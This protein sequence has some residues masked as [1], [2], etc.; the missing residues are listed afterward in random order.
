VRK[1]ADAPRKPAGSSSVRSG[2]KKALDSQ[3]ATAEI[4]RSIAASQ[5]DLRGVLQAIAETAHRLFG[6][7]H[8]SIA[9]LEGEY[10]RHAAS[11]GEASTL[12]GDRATRIRV[13]RSSLFGRAVFDKRVV[14]VPDLERAA[15]EFPA[16]PSVTYG[17]IHTVAAA[18]LMRNGT[19][20]GAMMVARAEQRPFRPKELKLLESF[21]D[22]AVIAI[23]NAR[24]LEELNTRNSDLA[25]SLEQQTATA[26]ILRAIASSPGDANLVL[27][28]IAET[29]RRLFGALSTAITR[30][31]G[32]VFRQ[33]ASAGPF[34]DEL[35]ANL[36]NRPV[37]RGSVPGRA[38][39]DKRTVYIDDIQAR[40]S[41]FP[42][43]V[44]GEI[45]R[46]TTRTIVATPLLRKGEAIGH[47][48]VAH[49][50]VRPY[51]EKQIE[52]LESFA[53]QAVIAIE[54]A[55]L[56]DQLN[57]RNSDLA[58]SLEQRTATAEV[59][60]AIA[61][62]PG[63]ADLV[64]DTI[65]RTATRL[66]GASGSTITRID[67]GVFR[68]VAA[69]GEP[70]ELMQAGLSGLRVDR[71]TPP[72]R[73]VLERR[74]IHVEDIRKERGEFPSAPSVQHLTAVRTLLVT[75]LISEGEAIGTISVRREEVRPFSAKEI[76]LLESFADQAVIAIENA[77][78]LSELRESLDR[79]TATSE[80][81]R[82]IAATP[83]ELTTAID[84]ICQTAANLFG[85]SSVGIRQLEGQI[86]RYVGAAGRESAII[87]SSFP[88][89]R[90]DEPSLPCRAV[91]EKIQIH[92]EDYDEYANQYPL[93]KFARASNVRTS[94]ATPLLHEGSAIGVL[95]VNRSD[96]RPFTDI[97]RQLIG[98][99]ADQAVIAIE[100][101]RLLGE[102]RESLDRQTA[103]SE[104]LGAI[105]SS[106]GELQPVFEAMLANAVRISGSKF[107]MLAVREGD[108]YR[109]VATHGVGTNFA[110]T[111]SRHRQAVPGTTLDTVLQKKE[112][113]QIADCL[114]VPAYDAVRAAN[115][116]YADVRTHLCVPML[117]ENELIGAILIY[118][119]E[120]LPFT[121]KQIELVENFAHQ[122]VIAIENARLLEELNTRNRDLAESL[123]QQTA[124]SEILR[125]IA[126][127]PGDATRVLDAIART[128]QRLLAASGAAIARID[129]EGTLRRIATAGQAAPVTASSKAGIDRGTPLGRA[130][131]EKR[132]VHVED[133]LQQAGEFPAAPALR[134]RSANRTILATP[135]MREDEAI[136]AINVT[137][138][139]VRPFTAKE[140]E[141]LES[142]ADQAVIAIENARLLDELN[143]RNRDLAESLEQ[144][145]ATA[146]ILSAIASTPGDA[147][148]VLAIISETAQRM[149]GAHHSTVALVDAGVFRQVALVGPAPQGVNP[150]V[151][152]PV[153]DHSVTGRAVL[154]KKIVEVE[155][156]QE[157]KADLRTAAP[158]PSVHTVVAVPMLREGIAIGAL[159]VARDRVERFS[160]KQLGLLQS[161]AHQAVIAIENARLLAELNTRNLDLAESLEQQTATSE[162]LSAV[163]SSP[164]ELAPVFDTILDNGLRLCDASMGHIYRFENSALHFAAIV[165]SPPEY[166][167]FLRDRGA[168]RPAED[169]PHA[170]TMR[171]KSPLQFPDIR[172]LPVY[173]SGDPGAV[174]AADLSG[175]RTLLC[176]PILG[177]ENPLGLILMY[178]SEVR[179][180][181]EK[182]ISLVESFADQAAIAI[183]NARL[184][185]ELNTRNR[186]LAESL[187]QQTATSEI[188]R[189]IAS[190]PEGSSEIFETI[191][192]SAQR[193]LR[194]DG[195]AIT[196]IDGG[197]PRRVAVSGL[198]TQVTGVL[199]TTMDRSTPGGRAIIDKCVVHVEDLLADPEEFPAAPGV[200]GTSPSRTVLSAPLMRDSEPIGSISLLRSEVR[201]FLPK[202]IEL[203]KSF[204]DQAVI[205]IE[206]ARLL[207]ELR[208]SLENQTASAEILRAIA[209]SPGDA[210]KV[211]NNIVATVQRLFGAWITGVCRVED[212]TF[213][214]VATAGHRS[215][216]ALSDLSR[217]NVG[218]GTVTGRS[219]VDRQ[220][221]HVAD[222]QLQLDEFPDTAELSRNSGTRTVI[223]TPLWMKG[224][225]IG[226]I[227]VACNEFR[228]FT[229][230]QIELLENFADQAVIAIENT[231]LLEEL[232][233]SLDRQT[234]TSEV[235]GAISS[236]LGELAPVFDA[237]LRNGLELCDASMGHVYR[238]EDGALHLSAIRGAPP[239]YETFLRDRGAHELKED[240]PQARAIRDRAPLLVPDVRDQP[241]YASGHP[242]TVAAVELGGQ[243]TAL[244]VPLFQ[245]ENPLGIIV[246][247]RRDVRPFSEK[248]V[249]LVEDF[250]DQAV[251]AI[252]NARLLE[253]LNTRNRDLSE[254][255]ERQT[256]TSEILRAIAS[257][258]ASIAPVLQIVAESAARLCEAPNVGVYRV[259]G[260]VLRTAGSYGPLIRKAVEDDYAMPF[261][262]GTVS[263]HAIIE[264][265]TIHIPD[266]AAVAEEYPDGPV[267]TRA[268]S[269]AT[270]TILVTPLLREGSAI[271]A[272]SVFRTEVRP[273]TDAQVQLVE[274]FADQAV[275]AIENA[276]LL[277]EL[278]TRNRDLS[279]SL[280]RQT[281]TSE[282]LRTI[283]SSPAE[284]ERALDKIAEV[285]ARMFDAA[286]VNIRRV[287]AA[288]LKVI[289]SAGAITKDLSAQLPDI[290]LDDSSIIG[291][292][293]VEGRL[294]HLKDP[295]QPDAADGFI[296]QAGGRL[297]QFFMRAGRRSAAAVPLMREAEA[298]GGMV[299][300]RTEVRPFTEAELAL[301]QS[302][303]D[304]AVIAIENA[305]LLSELRESLDRRTA[306]AEVLAV[307]SSSPG[308]VEPVFEAMLANAVRLCD[309]TEGSVFSAKGN[310]LR[311]IAGHGL[312]SDLSGLGEVV[313][314]PGSPPG[315]MLSTL[316]TVHVPDLLE[317]LEELPELRDTP[318]MAGA[319]AVAER[320]ARTALWVPM[321]KDG[322]VVGAFVLHRREP[323]PFSASQIGLVETFASQAVIAIENARLLDELNARNSDLAESLERQTATTDILRVISSSAADTQPV[324]D[325][326]VAAGLRL[327]PGETVSIALPAGDKV[328]VVA[329]GDVDSARAERWR[330]RFP[331][332]LS[333]DYMHSACILDCRIIDI[334]D[335]VDAPEE[336]TPGRKNFL[337]SGY[338][339]VTIMPMIRGKEAIGA[340]SVVRIAPGP[341]T[342][343]QRELLKTF[344]DQ[345]VI[346]IENARLLS[347]LR[348][349]RDAAERALDNLRTAQASLIQSEKMASLGQLTAGI[350]H[351]I[352]NPLNFV[353]NFADVSVE[354]LGELKETA[355]PALMALDEDARAEVEELIG[356]LT[357]NLE[358]VAEHGRRADGIVKS[359]LAHSRGSSGER[360]KVDLNAL[361]E[362]SLNLAYHGARAQDQNFN[363]TMEREPDP[364]L[365]PIEV[366]PQD[367]TRVFLNLFG[368]AFYAANKRRKEAGDAAY[369]PLVKV[370]TQDLGT[371][372]VI[373][374]RDNGVGIP[375]EMR[376][377]LFEPFFT[378][379]PTG[380]GTGLGLSISYEIVTKEHGGSIEVESVP[381]EFTEFR[382]VIPKRAGSEAG[383]R[384]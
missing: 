176:V 166:E 91:R 235:L 231:R 371:D 96:L 311:R 12:F 104:V 256:A 367:L 171:E 3:A 43:K 274:S 1:D 84:K 172:D 290:P 146:D 190:T 130:A 71:D 336:F 300:I 315:R 277:E 67:D 119:D 310:T 155:D 301:L 29:A 244:Y 320:G 286:G 369:R 20:V 254:S 125:A 205:A 243:R 228:P 154:E 11:A 120:V 284:A 279:E 299:V 298:I 250:A 324:F 316:K 6:G 249:A 349:A 242:G 353:N 17:T 329:I 202:E 139:E 340:V 206:N 280:E 381:G 35:L 141:L 214:Q 232:R 81:L 64:L 149:F 32:Q 86:L 37:D 59:L 31:D 196:R 292:A 263:G 28:T 270:R 332:P 121:D 79:Q 80:I 281:A 226:A 22:Q 65:A 94:V 378:T 379:K 93:S 133:I 179:P 117:R 328:R 200:L 185:E 296:Y 138:T 234:A 144:Q 366:V 118:R 343:K 337:E 153:D 158:Y 239:E 99:F 240:M 36:S 288:S 169:S 143:S 107:G 356:M 102:L 383:A 109:G 76:E 100:N 192:S 339:G 193:L 223:A 257:S 101:A 319:R 160:P 220:T 194:S 152:G 30:L 49:G 40:S 304:Q 58:E 145:T 357:G 106:P 264:K 168:Y 116:G 136:G 253:E 69:T 82:V 132:T 208:E 360:Q 213:C 53:D 161:F 72:G 198:A 97:E 351:E 167:A 210:D 342:D 375:P 354:L 275:I 233:E 346:A 52:L 358:K 209:S 45:G 87:K 95:T 305:R 135:L 307:I 237:I 25:E 108:G 251:I 314:A 276:R 5:G 16:S 184:L 267:H 63:D 283:A 34:S 163:S 186:D 46:Q 15:D 359:M 217:A 252:E 345:A 8:C 50:E 317:M 338:R 313:V 13:D 181:S 174:A 303:A 278:N 180:F 266:L 177:N 60:R 365:S 156:L 175:Q 170:R 26:E 150:L 199:G 236:S 131:L 68:N 364:S 348:T 325:A 219:I 187:E 291:A 261:S 322:S 127:S 221:V 189:A 197:A 368:N 211:L 361:V 98:S 56:L 195:A 39:L 326:I 287:D 203:L 344:A 7:H 88:D 147:E 245:G 18:P 331:F 173:A 10:F 363:V 142:F 255:L 115:P 318:A 204:A 323:R 382:I 265:R 309:A 269:A 157:L 347:E 162:V 282:I 73:A 2:S 159:T 4:L 289:G 355:A 74:T 227:T 374:V 229:R 259:D 370:T 42:G 105:S 260:D 83:G 224:E 89:L 122:A 225:V 75:P 110:H 273:F 164:G 191:V 114:A 312:A 48:T 128:A 188:L 123:E 302:F 111:L 54:N 238:L 380:E 222:I 27:D 140:I 47:M 66:F 23:E 85:A 341:L 113:I 103:T 230:T 372:V 306:I 258:P 151:G 377:R 216:N 90:L 112:T 137:R 330:S 308:E 333:R 92:V 21:A 44:A 129:D 272:I 124:T 70:G 201:P 178:R 218:R 41:E 148:G 38:V 285:A 384:Q 207:S 241:L 182:Q 24:L 19:A 335:V 376:P 61:G 55:Q 215:A 62:S 33:A 78:L 14:H 268:E 334:P 57:A 293:V 248:Q 212:D 77:R 262:R 51:S 126:S 271:G 350:A 295:T 247:Y 294:I 321:I 362:E 352:K 183:E 246:M 373:R 297:E 134:G 327:F 9:R 165:G